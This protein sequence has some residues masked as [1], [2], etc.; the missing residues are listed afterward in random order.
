MSGI[1]ECILKKVEWDII[2][3]NSN[4]SN[5]RNIKTIFLAFL[6]I[7]LFVLPINLVRKLF[8]TEERMVF[9]NLSILNEYNYCRKVTNKYFSK[10]LIMSAE[11]Q[12]FKMTKKV[13]VIFHNLEGYDSHL[14]F[15]EF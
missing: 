9:T 10:N 12:R 5:T 8:Y 2:E 13:S 1:F 3:C 6:L 7:K 15:K 11:E 4:S 14:I